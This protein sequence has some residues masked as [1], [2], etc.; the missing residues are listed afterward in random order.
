MDFEIPEMSGPKATNLIRQ[1]LYE[2]NIE[3]PIIALVAGHS[4]QKYKDKAI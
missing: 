4:E 1:Y 2:Q 3:Q